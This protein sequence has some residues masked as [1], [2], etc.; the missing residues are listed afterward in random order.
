MRA[1]KTS[2]VGKLTLIKVE[3]ND[4]IGATGYYNVLA[5]PHQP[6]NKLVNTDSFG[7]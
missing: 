2:N 6:T 4:L 7:F 5:I 1:E 3:R